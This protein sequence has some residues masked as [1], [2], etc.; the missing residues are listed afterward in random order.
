MPSPFGFVE[1]E[2]TLRGARLAY[3]VRLPARA[4]GAPVLL[5]L[6]GAGERGRDNAAQLAIGLPPR[7]AAAAADWPYAVVAP[8]CPQSLYWPAP[9][10][11]AIALAALDDAAARL[12]VDAGRVALTGISMGGYG[13]LELAAAWPGRFRA[14]AVVCGGVARLRTHPA[15][16][17]HGALGAPDPYAETARRLGRLPTWLFHGAADDVVPV[18]ESR[19]LSAALRDAG[20][21]VRYTEL[22]GVGHDAWT[23]AYATPELATWLRAHLA[24]G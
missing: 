8:Q 22:P 7:V 21:D 23:P 17:A 12:P 16:H 11:Q 4:G 19:R 24:A 9:D 1:R 5:F 20:G 10:A 2:T 18:E 13:A 15:L 14:L 6:H 3:R